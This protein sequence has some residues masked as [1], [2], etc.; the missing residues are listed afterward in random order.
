MNDEIWQRER[1]ARLIPYVLD[2]MMTHGQKQ[3]EGVGGVLT[4]KL[5]VNLQHDWNEKLFD[6]LYLTWRPYLFG[7][8]PYVPM[9][10]QPQGGLHSLVA[11]AQ[12]VR[13]YVFDRENK[14]FKPNSNRLWEEDFEEYFGAEEQNALDGLLEL[15]NAIYRDLDDEKTDILTT[16]SA[17]RDLQKTYIHGHAAVR[18]WLE[19][20]A[21]IMSLMKLELAQLE[22]GNRVLE[23]ELRRFALGHA[24]LED[25]I[26]R[27]SGIGETKKRLEETLRNHPQRGLARRVIESIDD[28]PT[29]GDGYPYPIARADE[30]GPLMKAFTSFVRQ[31]LS[32]L[33][34]AGDTRRAGAR[35]DVETGNPKNLKWYA[36]RLKETV[37]RLNIGGAQIMNAYDAFLEDD[38]DALCVLLP[39]ILERIESFIERNLPDP[40]A[41]NP[42]AARESLDERQKLAIEMFSRLQDTG[43]RGV[44]FISIGSCAP[45]SETGDAG[46]GKDIGEVLKGSG[47]SVTEVLQRA[48][49]QCL[50]VEVVAEK[51]ADCWVL[52]CDCS[53]GL[54][55]FAAEV[56]QTLVK[57]GVSSLPRFGLHWV[58]VEAE[59]GMAARGGIIAFYIADRS[60][61]A[62]GGDIVISAQLYNHLSE[63][64]RARC[65]HLQGYRV[66][67]LEFEDE[68][69]R[70]NWESLG[71]TS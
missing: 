10:Y 17:C 3:K 54:V 62:R 14:L 53:D 40:E 9:T 5:L 65:T 22:P 67:C 63:Q 19:R 32:S 48:R 58:K 55:R 23:P 64:L 56:Q 49:K 39:L 60:G 13:T 8:I 42:Q 25:K 20:A 6:D 45:S 70:F 31:G 7:P 1:V 11:F 30:I 71:G 16:L 47:A 21:I 52:T 46:A 61:A 59:P 51:G 44:G 69:Y 57:D 35:V 27:Y 4:Y 43:E 28:A 50:E 38:R 37:E 68:L 34:V 15:Y 18:Y 29:I 2:Y 33:N 12:K 24:S 66:K 41:V 26:R 36:D